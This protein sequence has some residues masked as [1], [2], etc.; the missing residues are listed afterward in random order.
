MMGDIYSKK[1][2]RHWHLFGIL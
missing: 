2:V 1:M